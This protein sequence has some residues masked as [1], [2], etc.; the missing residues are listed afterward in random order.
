VIDFPIV[1]AH[2]HLWDIDSNY[3]P[4]LCDAAAVPFRY[5]DYAPLRR[6]YLMEDY[7]ADTA[8]Y[9]L[10]GSVFVETEW[11]ATDPLG[12][13]AWVDTVIDRYG[14]PT[15]SVAQAW[16]DRDDVGAILDAYARMARVRGVRHKPASVARPDLVTPGAP[17][18]MSD[19]R[20]RRG[21]ALLADRGL[22]FDLQCPWW[23]LGEARRLADDFPDTT[24]ILD[25]AGLP[26]DRS[27][28]GIAAWAASM[29]VVAGAGNV[30]VKISGLGQPGKAWSLADNRDIILRVIEIFG[31]GRAM[32]ASN[33]PVDGLVGSFATIFAGFDAATSDLT[34]SERRALFADNADRVYRMGIT[35]R[36][37]QR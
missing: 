4:W 35:V 23:H 12:E 31:T 25:H 36:D 8:G 28:E 2:H 30:T 19:P 24:I 29:R 37:S 14:L 33:F 20:W 21:Y 17:G 18:S 22:S 6:N 13:Q 9:Q 32:F 3:L 1:D 7:R 5:G 27:P 15:V 11:D 34:A 26:A 16:L 10:A